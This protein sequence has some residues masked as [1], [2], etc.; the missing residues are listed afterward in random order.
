MKYEQPEI[1]IR[2][3]AAEDTLS[4]SGINEGATHDPYTSSNPWE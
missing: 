2:T 1:I 3:F 4:A